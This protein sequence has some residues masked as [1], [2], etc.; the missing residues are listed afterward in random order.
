MNK[1]SKGLIIGAAVAAVSLFTVTAF[2]STPKTAGY[3]AFKEVLKANHMAGET[4]TSAT[5]NGNLTVTLDGKT[6]LTADG[7]T[8]VGDKGEDHIVSSDFG[9]TFMGVERSGSLY[10]SDNDKVYLVDRT[11]N[12]HYQVINLDDKHTGK[13]HKRSDDEAFKNRSLNR[14]EEALLDFLVGDLK[15]EFDVTNHA[16]GS[17][18]ITVDISKEEIP[19]PLRLLMD[20][21]SAEGKSKHTQAPKASPEWDRIKQLPFFQG[22]EGIDLEKQFPDLTVD[23]AIE[24]VKLQLKVD[25]NN[26]LHGVQGQLEVSG[27]D[28]SGAAHRVELGGAG[29]FSDINTTTPEV[30]DPAGNFIETIDAATFDHRS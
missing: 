13:Q 23:V 7:T 15:E 21:A 24:R 20:V 29:N 8:K 19:L 5:I 1:K 30:Y 22:F 18:T 2:A 11:H 26:K 9:F 28:E 25:A 14:A 27:K 16:D 12:R 3:D 4:M 10:S 6:V 17:K